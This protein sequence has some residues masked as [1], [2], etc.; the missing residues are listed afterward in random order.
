MLQTYTFQCTNLPYFTNV[1]ARR[2][3]LCP[4]GGFIASFFVPC[5]WQLELGWSAGDVADWLSET[6]K[7]SNTVALWSE[8]GWDGGYCQ[9]GFSS[10][11]MCFED[12]RLDTKSLP[13]QTQFLVCSSSGTASLCLSLS[14]EN[15]SWFTW[16][17][18]GEPTHFKKSSSNLDHLPNFQGENKKSLKTPPSQYFSTGMSN[19]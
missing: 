19:F 10:F 9:Q 16:G 3:V 18:K 11:C 17:C 12:Y 13:S 2:C 4:D 14:L 6:W 1:R 8:R 15:S 5:F 7:P